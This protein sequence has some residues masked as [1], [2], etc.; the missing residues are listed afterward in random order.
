MFQS[1]TLYLCTGSGLSWRTHP[2]RSK[3]EAV[4]VTPVGGLSG[5]P[6]LPAPHYS[7]SQTGFQPITRTSSAPGSGAL[8]CQKTQTSIRQLRQVT[9]LGIIYLLRLRHVFLL[10]ESQTPFVSI[11]LQELCDLQSPEFY[12]ACAFILVQF[13]TEVSQISKNNFSIYIYH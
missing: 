12:N 6:S 3:R 2:H 10:C 1:A 5:K 9:S 8:V 11:Q 13:S 7:C 4:P